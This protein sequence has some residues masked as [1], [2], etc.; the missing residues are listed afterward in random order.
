MSTSPTPIFFN[1]HEPGGMRAHSQSTPSKTYHI[2]PAFPKSPRLIAF[3]HK[4]PEAY[5][6][7][8]PPPAAG[9]QHYI[10]N[11]SNRRDNNPLTLGELPKRKLTYSVL[12]HSLGLSCCRPGWDASGH[13]L[14]LVLHKV[15]IILV[16][17]GV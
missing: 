14:S 17:P 5:F 10:I 9:M 11:T 15:L 16:C 3:T 2:I 6:T 4:I 1:T 13:R 7:T 12:F 8:L